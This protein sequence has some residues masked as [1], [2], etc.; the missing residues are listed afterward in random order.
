[1]NAQIHEIERIETRLEIFMN[2]ILCK[3]IRQND[4]VGNISEEMILR[5]IRAGMV[6]TNVQV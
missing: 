6:V 2:V 1:M 3:Q 5:L 4:V